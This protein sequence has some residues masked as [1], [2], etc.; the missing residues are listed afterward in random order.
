MY[1]Y[2]VIKGTNKGIYIYRVIKGTRVIKG[3]NI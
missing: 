3:I 1:V 2:R